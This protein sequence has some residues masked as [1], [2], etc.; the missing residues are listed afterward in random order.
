MTD[1]EKTV[2]EELRAIRAEFKSDINAVH[3]KIDKSNE[4]I[5]D[6]KEGMNLFKGKVFG[7]WA[8]LTALINIGFQFMGK[9]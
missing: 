3:L 9:K 2:L 6:T 1:F 4:N 7:V 5:N 8:V